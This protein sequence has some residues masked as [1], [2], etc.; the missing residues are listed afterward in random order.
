MA[1]RDFGIIE[2]PSRPSIVPLASLVHSLI[3]TAVPYLKTAG[4]GRR[5][6]YHHSSVNNR[7]TGKKDQIKRRAN[8][9]EV[10]KQLAVSLTEKIPRAMKHGC[11]RFGQ[12]SCA[13]GCLVLLTVRFFYNSVSTFHLQLVQLKKSALDSS[14]VQPWFVSAMPLAKKAAKN[15]ICEFF[16]FYRVDI[17]VYTLERTVNS[18]TTAGVYV[19]SR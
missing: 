17:V 12:K 11:K 9:Y 18:V 2:I 15:D 6:K 13:L 10:Y 3:Q 19:T 8:I 1:S 4:T 5:G 14:S 7:R 16:V